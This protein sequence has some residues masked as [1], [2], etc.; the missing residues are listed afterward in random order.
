MSGD[1]VL[2]RE[3]AIWDIEGMRAEEILICE[4]VHKVHEKLS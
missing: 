4:K 2:E 3:A 1:L